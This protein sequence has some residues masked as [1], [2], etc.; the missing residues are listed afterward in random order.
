MTLAHLRQCDFTLILAT[1]EK[2]IV[3]ASLDQKPVYS[4]QTLKQYVAYAGSKYDL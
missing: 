4:K 2:D 1:F 3:A